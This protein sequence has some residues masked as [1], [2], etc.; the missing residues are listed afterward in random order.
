MKHLN[1]KVGAIAGLALVL[2]FVGL[3]PRS[4]EFKVTHFQE[5]QQTITEDGRYVAG[6]PEVYQV[7][8]SPALAWELSKSG[9]WF[10]R[11]AAWVAL[12]G[13]AV[14][15]ALF[16]AGVISFGVGSVAGNYIIFVLLAIAAAC[17]F[18]AYSAA[19]SNNYI[20]LSKE[21]YDAVKGDKAKIEQLFREKPFIK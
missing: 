19:F 10:W 5:V 11:T 2:L 7:G 18:A 13:L 8:I 21:K 17:Y 3:K 15:L 6:S 1:W 12:V 16:A 4:T 9:T 14:F 20:E